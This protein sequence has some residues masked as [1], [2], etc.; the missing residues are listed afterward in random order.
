MYI[1]YIYNRLG[2]SRKK[3]ALEKKKL[4]IIDIRLHTIILYFFVYYIIE[5]SKWV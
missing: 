5:Y 2:G 3:Q 4:E 1:L